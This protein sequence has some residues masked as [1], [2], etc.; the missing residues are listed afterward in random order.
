MKTLQEYSL[1]VHKSFHQPDLLLGI[2]KVIAL[3]IFLITVG[4]MYLFGAIYG[5]IG[6]VLYIP[7]NII[8]KN[9][10]RLLEYAFYSLFQI[11][12]LEG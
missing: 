12:Y 6:I 2:P 3:V 8:S 9:D 1:P 11:D 4:M 10:P 5:L 7:C